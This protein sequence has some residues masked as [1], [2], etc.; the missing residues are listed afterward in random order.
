M[1]NWINPIILL[2]FTTFAYSQNMQPYKI[3]VDH[4]FNEDD[5]AVIRNGLEEFNTPFFGHE[6]TI[7][8]LICLKNG[9]LILQ[10]LGTFD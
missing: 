8:F 1:T 10:N 4:Q 5:D 9:F 7:S 3:Q 6:K 2:F